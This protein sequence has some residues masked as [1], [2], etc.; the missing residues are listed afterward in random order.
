MLNTFRILL[1]VLLT[2]VGGATVQGYPHSGSG[3]R[4][5]AYT[6]FGDVSGWSTAYAYYSPFAFTA[7]MATAGTTKSRRL[8]RGSDSHQCDIMAS[9]TGTSNTA[10]C[11]TGG[12]NGQSEASFGSAT[13]L[14]VVTWYDQSGNGRDLT[15]ASAPLETLTGIGGKPSISCDASI[16]RHLEFLAAPGALAP[17]TSLV[18]AQGGAVDG[19]ALAT[20]NTSGSFLQIFNSTAQVKFQEGATFAASATASTPH[21]IA[22]FGSGVSSTSVISVDG[23]ETT[24]DAGIQGFDSNI[25]ICGETVFNSYMTGMVGEAALYVGTSTP[26]QRA[27]A[28]ANQHA[29]FGF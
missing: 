2:S 20:F 12:D 29:R 22:A 16:S 9:V 18:V 1:V 6:G 13:N 19:T 3:A 23:V 14:Q 15:G 21:A 10:N 7:A 4:S 17:V 26:T 28:S 8:A 27:A 25:W 5:V 11:S 24:G